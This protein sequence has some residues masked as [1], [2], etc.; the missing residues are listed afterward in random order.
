[1]SEATFEAL[2]QAVSNHV[3]EESPGADIVRDWVLLACAMSMD[4]DGD[5]VEIQ[6]ESSHN[7]TPYATTG[8]LEWGKTVVRG[9]DE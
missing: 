7:T 5:E 9:V 8:L 2:Q 3:L 6:V 1:V 4:D